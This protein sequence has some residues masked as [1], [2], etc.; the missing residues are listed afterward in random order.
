MKTLADD[1]ILYSIIGGSTFGH[2][3]H[4]VLTIRGSK[5]DQFGNLNNWWTSEQH[6]LLYKDQV[7]LMNQYSHYLVVDSLYINAI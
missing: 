6:P 7:P 3:F 4:V 2:E 5:Y 1:A